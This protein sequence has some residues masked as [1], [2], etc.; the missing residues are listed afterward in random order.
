VLYA[1]HPIPER[2]PEGAVDSQ[3]D[4]DETSSARTGGSGSACKGSQ[5]IDARAL[6]GMHYSNARKQ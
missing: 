4:E 3:E 6:L 1:H 5:P 2:Y